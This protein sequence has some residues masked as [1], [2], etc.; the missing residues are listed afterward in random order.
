MLLKLYKEM[1]RFIKISLK[2]VGSL[3][4]LSLTGIVGYFLYCMASVRSISL[5]G[6]DTYS[7][8]VA[9][10]TQI[11]DRNGVLL[12]DLSGE[13]REY[14]PLRDIPPALQLATVASE[15][16]RFFQH[17]GIDL[18][19][20]M[21]ALY[22]DL[23]RGAIVEGG[24]TITQQ[25]ARNLY[26]SQTRTLSRKMQEMAIAIRLERHY[27]KEEILEMYL[28]KVYYGSG[29]YG[30]GMASKIYFGKPV[31][32]LSLSEC[33]L[34]AAIPR[35]PNDYSPYRNPEL[36]IKMRNIVL[37]N[38]WRMKFIT[39]E[40]AE[41]AKKEP[42]KLA[43]KQA[44]QT[45]RFKAPYFVFWIIEQLGE[46]YGEDFVYRSGLKIYTTLDIK[47]QEVAEEA[48]RKGLER[49]RGLNVHQAALVA[50]DYTTGY[51]IAMV[52]GK[53]FRESQFNR[54]VQARVQPGSAFKIFVYTAAIDKGFEPGD[55]IND[56]PVAYRSANGVWRPKNVDG[57]FR[58]SVTLKYAFAQSINVPA[59]KLADKI[60]INT[61]IEY[62]H[63]MGIT[64]PLEPYLSTAIGSSAVRVLDM[65]S[66]IGVIANDGVRCIPQ[67]I[68]KIETIKG[69]ILEDNKPVSFPVIPEE[70]A[71]TMQ[72]MLREVVLRGTGRRASS[73][74][75]AAGK[76]GTSDDYRSAWF[77]GYTPQL[78]CAVWVGNDDYSPMSRVF[79][80]TVPCGIWA[81]FMKQAGNLWEAGN[82]QKPPLEGEDMIKVRI[83]DDTGALAT[84]HCPSTHIQEFPRGSVPTEKCSLHTGNLE[85]VEICTQSGKIA[86]PYCPSTKRVK[87]PLDKRP[88][89]LCDIHKAP[90]SNIP[91]GDKSKNETDN[92]PL[93]TQ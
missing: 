92:Q 1:F 21:R 80:G 4:L 15:D 27:S 51:I 71:K 49:A 59:V 39:S 79:G 43:Y 77:V 2:I 3:L 16:R 22:Q 12:A 91:R 40:E 61:V 36:A 82:S 81:D 56:T 70:T 86:T 60:G 76:T 35:R 54:A 69:A 23:K 34:L 65:A 85:E 26:L 44:P 17:S 6:L 7:Q 64:T 90:P 88:T 89:E 8:V 33:A 18:R 11:Y 5:E 68:L 19:A 83:C 48:V 20:I 75:G 73:V 93:G 41:K 37:D 46:K 30:V 32:Q 13:M 57:R 63:K 38:M 25:V 9:N 53:D 52:G 50:L 72:A 24:S 67:G 78:A 10:A 14:V 28:N 74:P 55:T 29:A 66:A 45:A 84:L 47:L 58:G 31:S 62:A 87:V 42:L